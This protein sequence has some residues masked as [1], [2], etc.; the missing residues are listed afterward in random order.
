MSRKRDKPYLTRHDRAPYPKRRRPHPSPQPAVEDDEDKPATKPPPPP[1]VVVMGLLPHCSVL[2]LKSR[3]EIYGAISRIRIDRDG[4]GYITYRSKDSAEAAIAASLDASFGITIDSKRVCACLHYTR[5]S[6][7]L[8]YA[9]FGC[10]ENVGK[11]KTLPC[12]LVKLSWDLVTQQ[13]EFVCFANQNSVKP[14]GVW[15]FL[16]FALRFWILKSGLVVAGTGAMGNGS[17][18][19]ME[20]RCWGCR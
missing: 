4:V 5:H 20:G 3:L 16:V 7:Y 17:T 1:A 15:F 14:N 18:C 19:A 8:I 9:M 6:L 13:L 2:D 10:Q 12:I 11:S